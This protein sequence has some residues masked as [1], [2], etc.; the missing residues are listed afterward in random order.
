[1]YIFWY[2]HMDVEAVSDKTDKNTSCS[3]IIR[4]SFIASTLPFLEAGWVSRSLGG[5]FRGGMFSSCSRVSRGI[6]ATVAALIS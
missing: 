3:D 5:I 1:M 2:Y 6:A 4:Q